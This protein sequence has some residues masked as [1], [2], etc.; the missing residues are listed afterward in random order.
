MSREIEKKVLQKM[1]IEH[2]EKTRPD[3]LD[4][5]TYENICKDV[6]DLQMTLRGIQ[7]CFDTYVNHFKSM[8]GK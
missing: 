2:F 1:L 3:I 8:E 7:G 5:F 4:W 6:S